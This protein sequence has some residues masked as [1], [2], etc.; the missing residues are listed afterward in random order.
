MAAPSVSNKKRLLW[1][2][3]AIALVFAILL[4][5]IFYIQVVWSDELQQ[6]ALSQWTRDTSLTAERGMILDTNGV[7]LAQSGTAYKVLVWPQRVG[8]AD[9]VR[10]ARE[11]SE[12]L[13]LDYESV[14]AKVSDQTKMEI[15]LKRAVERDMVDKIIA[16]KLGAG[17]GT[18]VDIKRYYPLSSTFSQLIGFTTV[19]GAG[20]AG[21]EQKYDK[22]LSGENGR[23]IAE[24]DGRGNPLP[25]GIEEI[26]SPWNGARLV[27]TTDS[28]VQSILEKELKLAFGVNSAKNAQCIIM[29]CKTGEIVALGSYP[30]F[31]LNNPPRNDLN[32]LRDLMR[33]RIVAD[34][35]EPG[36]TFK[37]VTL[38]AALDSQTVSTASGY[39]CPGFKIVNGEKVRC[40][41]SG[42]HGSQELIKA[43]QNS[44]NVA[45]MTMALAMGRETFYDYIYE[46]GFGSVTG[47]G[48]QG[49]AGGIVTQEKYITENTLARIGFGQS[50]A[51]TPLQLAT[52]VCAAVNGG[53]LMQPYVVKQIVASSG[54]ILLEN[55][56]T[57]VRRVISEETSATVRA[58]LES[59]VTEGSGRNAGI[60]GYRVGGKT[61]TAQKY[62][63]GR[64]ADGKLIASF[65][66]FAP[67]DD[68]EFVCLLLVDEP[69]V[70]TVFGSTVAAPFVKVILEET[71]RHYGYLPEGSGESVTVPDV[72]GLSVSDAKHALEDVGLTADYQATDTVTAQVPAAGSV[73][74]KGSDVLLY[75]E[76]TT[77]ET[78]AHQE[79][80]TVTVPDVTNK[81]RLDAHDILAKE[82]LTIRID[83]PDQSGLAIRQNPAAGTVVEAGTEVFVEFSAAQMGGG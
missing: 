63:N 54:E 77:A 32:T 31:D 28:A 9:R 26:I 65:I 25:Y 6:K 68:P 70:G 52:A 57:V 42:G 5:R 37:I 62:E 78:S 76:S 71:L 83:P 40:W 29:N 66:G 50:I 43:V 48:I 45:F 51:V 1:T 22:Y 82:G 73:V 14:L 56:P 12:L 19:D 55:T 33:N 79:A 58:I 41:K 7:V 75:T 15:I 44:C 24:T 3:G 64:V 67:A 72:T 80:E 74:N 23:M 47:S 34:A 49:E 16:L 13:E 4:G 60:P 21:L 46:F 27:L 59:V 36:S 35:Y 81:S 11:L 2:L 8:D 53:E 69:Q 20:Q 61:G 39:Y 18:A 17:V 10:V 30:D 38:S